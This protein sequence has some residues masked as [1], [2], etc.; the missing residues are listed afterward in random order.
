MIHIIRNL[1]LNDEIPERFQRVGAERRDTT[2]GRRRR[3]EAHEERRALPRA[4]Y[5]SNTVIAML[6]QMHFGKLELELLDRLSI[7]IQLLHP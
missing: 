3:S 7:Y 1:R 2:R 5:P 4:L 6:P